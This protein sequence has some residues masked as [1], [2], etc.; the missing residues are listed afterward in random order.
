MEMLVPITLFICISMVLILR[1]ITK[2]LGGLIEAVT[3]DRTRARS[4]DADNAR[5]ALLIEHIGNRLDV[6]DERL[7]FTERLVGAR[8]T[9]EPARQLARSRTGRRLETERMAL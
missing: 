7:D 1:P 6:M 8:S 5:V 2:K 3:L 4:D 9:V